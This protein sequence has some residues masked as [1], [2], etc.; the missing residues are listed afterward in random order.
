[1]WDLHDVLEV[2]FGTLALHCSSGDKKY[3]LLSNHLFQRKQEHGRWKK[4]Q[5]NDKLL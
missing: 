2:Y 4:P 3:G 1:M 5:G